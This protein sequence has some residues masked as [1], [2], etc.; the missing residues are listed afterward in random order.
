MEVL[1][2]RK[3]LDWHRVRTN[4]LSDRDV[5]RLHDAIVSRH[6]KHLW[7][8]SPGLF[9]GKMQVVVAVLGCVLL[10]WGA[11]CA[12]QEAA[13]ALARAGSQA[14]GA[15]L[16]ELASLTRDAL[17]L[18]K[19]DAAQME[20]LREEHGA[21]VEEILAA[22]ARSVGAVLVAILSTVYFTR[23]LLPGEVATWRTTLGCISV[24]RILPTDFG[25]DPLYLVNLAMVAAGVLVHVLVARADVLSARPGYAPAPTAAPSTSSAAAAASPKKGRSLVA[26]MFSCCG[27]CVLCVI[28][29]FTLLTVSLSSLHIDLSGDGSDFMTTFEHFEARQHYKTLGLDP[30]SDFAEVKRAYRSLSRVW[31]PDKCK[32]D[33][34]VCVAKFNAIRNAYEHLSAQQARESEG[35][36]SR[37]EDAEDDHAS[38]ERREQ[39]AGQRR[40]RRRQHHTHDDL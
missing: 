3:E 11:S 25:D 39:R 6:R 7:P 27:K 37:E 19:L 40:K 34:D 30:G 21:V 13:D 29:G 14:F 10:G 38:E 15:H 8:Y 5:Q 36:F 26:R 31:H 9:K 23:R 16:G 4:G 2:Q 24:F 20:T 17:Q 1:D 22:L 32:E 33:P 12:G 35:W 18:D 28:I